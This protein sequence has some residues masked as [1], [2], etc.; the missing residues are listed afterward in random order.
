MVRQI[1]SRCGARPLEIRQGGRVPGPSPQRDPPLATGGHPTQPCEVRRRGERLQTT[2]M[3]GTNENK[4]NIMQWNAEGVSNKKEILAARLCQEDID[5]ACV[6]ET[7]LNENRRFNMRGYQVFRK[8]RVGRKKGGVVILV[9]NRIPAQE[10]KISCTDQAEINAVYILI[11]NQRY[12]IF[13]V[14]SPP[15]RDLSLQTLELTGDKCLIAGDFNSHSEAWGYDEADKRGE[16]VE[17]WQVE[18]NLLL[19]NDPEDPPTFYS[20][21]WMTTSTPDL[22]FATN[23]LAR[24]ATR[25]VLDQLGGSDHR[26]IKITLDLNYKPDETKTFPRWNYK[27]ADW[28]KFSV[29]V[30]QYS[31]TI[32]NKQKHVNGKIKALNQA[33]LKAATETIPRGARKDYKP[34]WTEELQQMED[35]LE[36]ARKK[37]EEEPTQ[38]N[39]IALKAINAKHRQTLTQ[40]MRRSWHEKTEN[41]NFEKDGSKLWKLAKHLNDEKSQSSPITLQE[42]QELLR[43]KKAADCFINQY[44]ETSNLSVP[45]ERQK[46]VKEAQSKIKDSTVEPLMNIPFKMEELENGLSALQLKKSPGPDKISNEMLL[47]LGPK[48]KKKL[49]QLFNDSWK[50]GN[51]PQIW[52]DAIM[53]PVH[54]KGKDKTDASSYRPISLTSCTGKLMERLINTRLMWHLESKNHISPEQAAFRQNRSTEDQVT[55]IAQEI[56]DGFQEGKHT[57]TV[58]IDLEKAFDKVWKTGLK[59]KLRQCGVFGRMFQWIAKYLQNRT[60]RTQVNH[61]FSKKKI[62]KEGVPQGGVLSPTLFLVFIKDIIQRM[63]KNVKGAIYADDLAI[64]CSEENVSTANYRL[65]LALKEIENWTKSWL[66]K[67]NERKTTYTLFT[68]STKAQKVELTVNS[69]QIQE[70]KS[71][72]Y[73]GVTLD[74]RLT[75]K[76]QLQNSQ[77]RAK[78]RMNL[79]KKLAGTHWGADQTVLKKLYVGRI[80]PVLE[81]CSAATATAAKTNTVRHDRLQNQAMRMMTGAMRSTPIKALETTTGLQSLED[82]RNQKTLTQATKFKCLQNHPMRGRMSAPSKGRLKRSSFLNHSRILERR[83]PVLL[84]H[85]YSDIPITASI[86]PWQRTNFPTISLDIPGI[87]QKST[88]SDIERK[89]LTTEFIKSSYPEKEWTHAYTDGSATDATKDGGGGVYIKFTSEETRIP[90]PTGKYSTNYKAEA[91][92]LERAVAL[93][94]EN[95]HKAKSQVVVFTDALS[96][97]QALK[98]TQEKKP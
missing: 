50:T 21:R 98:N 48:S 89:S 92:A 15:D 39:S 66:V 82:R 81:Y 72:T 16:E 78:I 33:I 36:E 34:Y 95:T 62:L 13:N 53:V 63:P 46:E 73:L 30:D 61:H 90:F 25:T 70:D 75:W 3:T 58:W 65:K 57:L 4:F 91:D 85:E 23:D 44:A 77:V 41:L 71:P 86:P 5:I 54:K 19:L 35:N 45:A 59:L 8:D 11:E 83:N 2:D 93:I 84:D 52:R 79:M 56:E 6:Q 29:L 49:L 60:A 38:E 43:G 26:P 96:V 87:Q 80:R 94:K 42:G 55:Y 97:L 40:E 22:A 14:Y 68:L 69:Q 47:H 1:N 24:I 37:A 67:L 20:R 28:E 17:D 31:S 76:N 18:N 88:Q 7:H 9:K 10:I 12:N 27:K 64:W 51:V 32:R 74:C